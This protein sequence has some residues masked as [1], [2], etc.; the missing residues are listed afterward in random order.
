MFDIISFQLFLITAVV[1]CLTP[2]IDTFYILSRSISQGKVAG[3]YSVLGISSGT[4][5]H[6]ILA[7]IGLSTLLK[8]SVLIFTIVKIVGAFYLLFL[9]VQMIIKKESRFNTFNMAYISPKKI[10]LTRCNYKCYKS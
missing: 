3:V 5:V 9:G 2:G 4:V 7:A 8:T 10:V 6:T 1:I